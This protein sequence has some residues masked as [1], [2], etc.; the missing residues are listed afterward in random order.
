MSRKVD[1]LN[2][3]PAVKAKIAAAVERWL[4]AG[5]GDDRGKSL[6]GL[7][8]ELKAIPE[9]AGRSVEE[10]AGVVLHWHKAAVLVLG[11]F[12]VEEAAYLFG[13]SWK[14]VKCPAGADAARLAFERAKRGKPPKCAEEY[15][16]AKLKLL[17]SLC[18]ELQRA[19]GARPFFLSC[20]KAGALLGIHYKQANV[21][22]RFLRKDGGVLRES[23]LL[24]EKPR[25]HSLRKALRYRF[26]GEV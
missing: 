22:L 15:G 13:Q 20:R 9:V 19:Q 18:F 14:I 8:R 1:K 12:P 21:W 16:S 2:V 25:G 23:A 26:V 3:S 11:E 6:F 24:S 7:A 17:I 4:P 10:L 5:S